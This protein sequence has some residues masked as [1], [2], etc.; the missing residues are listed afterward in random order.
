[1]IPVYHKL[2][3]RLCSPKIWLM[4]VWWNLSHFVAVL[5]VLPFPGHAQQTS[6]VTVVQTVDIHYLTHLLW[7]Q[8]GMSIQRS[9]N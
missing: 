4:M 1:M 3:Q 9:N 2:I 6:L 5:M 7:P 8:P